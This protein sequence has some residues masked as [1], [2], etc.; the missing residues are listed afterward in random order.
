MYNRGAVVDVDPYADNV[1]GQNINHRLP[2]GI[3]ATLP[4]NITAS[5]AG[6]TLT[7]TAK[8]SGGIYHG[9][10]LT[11]AGIAAN[12][13]LVRQLT[14]DPQTGV[15]TWEISAANTVASEVMTL[16]LAPHNCTSPLH[17]LPNGASFR[18]GIV[19]SAGALDLAAGRIA[20]ALAMG[21]RQ[22]VAWY[23]S[24]GAPGWQ[25]FSAATAP[26]GNITLQDAGLV[27]INTAT[28][29]D[30]VL[31]LN[32]ATAGKNSYFNLVDA[33][34]TKFQVGRASTNEFFIQDT[35]N[36]ARAYTITTAG[37][38]VVGEP[39][40]NVAVAGTLTLPGI[41]SAANCTGQP[42]KSIIATTGTGVLVQCP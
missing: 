8:N 20:P 32:P 16:E 4:G 14:G 24:A 33:N 23:A 36:G 35:A 12:T 21:Q 9:Q 2:C 19:I 13:D 10:N 34:T 1:G 27:Q 41:V 39:A 28:G 7:I 18:E 30:T 40:K 37:N 3:G 42:S 6:K 5:S 25:M 26:S 17:I 22:S 15:G 29:T 31:S 11:G 38:T